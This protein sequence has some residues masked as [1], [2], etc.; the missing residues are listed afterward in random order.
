MASFFINYATEV[1]TNTP[2]WMGSQLLAGGQA[3]FTVGR[4][5]GVGLIYLVRPRWV[6]LGFLTLVIVFTA[7]SIGLTGNAGI[8]ML[9][10]ILLFESICFPTI[11]ALGMRGLGRHTKAGSGFLVGAV[12]GGA[13]G[14]PLMGYVA[15]LYGTGTS[16]FVPLIFF[17]A[18]WTYPLAVNFVPSYR[19]V[20]DSFG[21]T[22]RE[23][24]AQAAGKIDPEA[25]MIEFAVQK[26][27]SKATI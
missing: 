8:A 3:A 25:E 1:R 13:V 12:L 22:S 2:N 11:V 16:M 23:V 17:V 26:R 19:N 20:A 6:F 9:Y 18:A 4:F 14:P 21:E 10:C 7:L 15:D 5:V 27:A 24:E